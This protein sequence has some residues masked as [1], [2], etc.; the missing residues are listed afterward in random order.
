MDPSMAGLGATFIHPTDERLLLAHGFFNLVAVHINV[1]E[2]EAVRRQFLSFFPSPSMRPST[3][4]PTGWAC[5]QLKVDNQVVMYYLWSLCSTRTTFMKEIRE[6]FHLLESCWIFSNHSISSQRTTSY[7][8]VCPESQTTM[9]TNCAQ[10]SSR[11]SNA[12]LGPT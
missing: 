1:H 5:I 11:S 7:Q 4:S 3:I 6:H 2:L 8:N 10:H 9:T 12:S